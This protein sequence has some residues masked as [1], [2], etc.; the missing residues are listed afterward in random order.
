VPIDRDPAEKAPATDAEEMHEP[1]A[2]AFGGSE[3]YFHRR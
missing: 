2:G 1:M 3:P